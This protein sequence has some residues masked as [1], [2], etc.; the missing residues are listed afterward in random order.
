MVTERVSQTFIQTQDNG[1]DLS[2][3]EGLDVS[4]QRRLQVEKTLASVSGRFVHLVDL[5]NS[6]A[7]TLEDIGRLTGADRTYLYLAP[8][9][10]SWGNHTF[11]WCAPHIEPHRP[12]LKGLPTADYPWWTRQLEADRVVYV[13]ELSQ[14][15]PEA[16]HATRT[17]EADGDQ[18]LLV[19]P[20][21]SSSHLI[22]C[23]GLDNSPL[24][25]LQTREDV[26]ILR[27]MAQIMGKA[28]EQKRIQDSLE[29][30]TAF[31]RQVLDIN[32]H[33][34]FAKDREGRFTLV[35]QAVADLYGTTVDDLLGKSDVD[36]HPRSEQ[37]DAFRRD[38]LEVLDSQ[39]EKTIAEELTTDHNEQLHWLY[40]IKRPVI[41]RDGDPDQVLG[42]STDI[43]HLKQTEEALKRSEA[44]FRGIFD[45]TGIGIAI[46]TL[47]D[48][49]FYDANPTL[50]AM[51]GYSATELMAMRWVE[52]ILADDWS[53][54]QLLKG[55]L[56]RGSRK[57][58]QIE[59]RL[60]HRL[61]DFVWAH[62]SSSLIR[63]EDERPQYMVTTVEDIS[64]RKRAEADREKLQ[65]Q[66]LQAQ[67]MEALGRLTAGI[68]H[69]FNNLLT[70]INGF[71][72]LMRARLRDDDPLKDLVNRISRSGWHA[73]DLVQQLLVFSRKETGQPQV[74]DI[75]NVVREID[76][77]LQRIIGEDIELVTILAADMWPVKAD[78]A[79]L[80]QVIV[81]LAVNA[82]DAMPDGGQ[83]TIETSKI[84]LDETYSESHF[85]VKPGDYV[86]LA[87]TDTGI[88]MSRDVQTHIFEPFFTTKGSGK[89]TGLGLSTVYGI[90]EQ[91]QGHIWVYS[92][93]ER[94][95]TF[96]IYLPRTQG[97]FQVKD[98]N[99]RTSDLPRGEETILLLEDN[100]GVRDLTRWLLEEQGYSVI[101]A[102]DGDEAIRLFGAQQQSPDL[103]LTDVVIPDVN[104][105]TVA[106]QLRLAKPSLKV[107]YMSGYTDEAIKHLGVL[108][109]GVAF[110]RKPFNP[111]ELAETVRT[112]LDE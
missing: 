74:L 35:N 71:A 38:D 29:R 85:N 100:E 32:P 26:D 22:G 86:L 64:Q 83:L 77:M 8:E 108:E 73:A 12:N 13:E 24:S 96:K 98:Q 19:L 41:G 75:N 84:V 72:E 60:Q 18:S 11:E 28:L 109:E 21:R 43:T 34:V 33:L 58:F 80:E 104:G 69:D 102:A 95:T 70:A 5:E 99:R 112:V 67:K 14:L 36:F 61:E 93:P 78:P 110:L 23:L 66:F 81:N 10:G 30:Q 105:K 9:N 76:M 44:Y 79:Q 63:D 42:V 68:A 40:T 97:R 48:D 7:D 1:V 53:D 52:L 15:P 101:C 107:L 88:G 51:V 27:V 37:V 17:A 20:V 3:D 111:N 31:L 46:T 92:E 25:P 106:E 82:R 56:C 94:G 103:L 55:H 89:G 4:L 6:L 59:L 54:F 90:V 45:N 39:Q 62:L 2:I 91:S 50:H 47:P 49:R 16:V 57:T 87:V 65:A